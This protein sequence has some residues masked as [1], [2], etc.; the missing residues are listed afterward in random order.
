MKS[1]SSTLT[2]AASAAIVLQAHR[3]K[4]MVNVAFLLCQCL[5]LDYRDL[6]KQHSPGVNHNRTLTRSP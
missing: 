2:G 5:W 4:K 3:P 6:V 1:F